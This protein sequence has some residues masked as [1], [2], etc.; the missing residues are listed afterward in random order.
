MSDYTVR[1]TKNNIY[2]CFA[3][4]GVKALKLSSILVFLQITFENYLWELSLRIIFENYLWEFAKDCKS[5][6]C[7]WI[8]RTELLKQQ[9]LEILVTLWGE[10]SSKLFHS[11]KLLLPARW[12][13]GRALSW[14]L[15][16]V[17]ITHI[18]IYIYSRVGRFCTFFECY[19][20]AGTI[21]L[22]T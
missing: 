20:F 14:G 5:V 11:S 12:R 21:I 10:K 4:K 22:M 2:F 3:G 7:L 18:Y 13:C 8:R 17:W 15:S 16:S 9:Y 1:N 19:A 6:F